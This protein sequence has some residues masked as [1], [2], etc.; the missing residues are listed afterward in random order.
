MRYDINQEYVKLA[1]RRIEEFKLNF[2]VSEL[3][4]FVRKGKTKKA[5]YKR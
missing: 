3:F 2:V 4:N 5:K 1:E